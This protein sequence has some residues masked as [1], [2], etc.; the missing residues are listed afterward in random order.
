MGKDIPVSAASRIELGSEA[1]AV[2]KA[3]A[4]AAKELASKHFEVE[5]G[6]TQIFRIQDEAETVR[7][8]PIKL[9]EVNEN[10]VPSGVMPL[11]FGPAPASGIPFSSVIVEV[12]PEEFKRIQSHELKLPEG[13]EIGEELP[14]P[15][16][17]RGGS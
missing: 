14:K 10:T 6:L 9:L 17:P 13:W 8:E 3:K 5:A 1:D 7:G 12:T 4:K 16:D 11:R 15:S 2:L